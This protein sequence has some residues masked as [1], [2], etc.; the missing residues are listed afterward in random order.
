MLR[1]TPRALVSQRLEQRPADPPASLFVHGGRQPTRAELVVFEAGRPTLRELPPEPELERLRASGTPLWLRIQGVG[2]RPLLDQI[3]DR[4]A[5]PDL[6]R[7][8]LLDMPQRPRVECLGSVVLV[9]LHRFR[10]PHEA[11]R[12]VSDQVGFLL[13]PGLLVTIEES[14]SLPAFGSLTDWLLTMAGPVEDRDLDDILHHLIDDLLDDL[15]PILEHISNRLDDLEE[16]TLR[17]PRPGQLA[18]AFQY[19]SNVRRIRRQIWPLRHQIRMMLRQNQSILGPEAI[20]G[21][22][23]MAELVELLYESSEALRSHLD[24]IT[25]S[26]A[27]SVGNRMNQVMKTLTILTSIFAPLTFIAGIYGMNF[28]FMPELKW[29]WGYFYVLLL[30]AVVAMIQSYWLWRRGWFQDWT[31]QR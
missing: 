26:Y 18:L 23:D 21:F 12:L 22:Q 3:L 10:S 4:F 13:L 8:P 17:R 25:E 9:V 5:V 15:F 14:G 6:L 27:A 29:A 11:T 19:R 7:P 28:E 1:P 30:M 16:A 31:A 24:A 20:G 2:D